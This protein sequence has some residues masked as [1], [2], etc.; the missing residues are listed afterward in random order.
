VIVTGGTSAQLMLRKTVAGASAFTGGAAVT[1]PAL[2]RLRRVG[3][4]FSA[5]LSTDDG[6]T[7]TPLADGEIPGFGD[8]PYYVGLVG[9]SRSQ[10]VR[11]TTEF[12][13]VSITPT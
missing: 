12:D 1:L 8:A 7:W 4:A 3:T 6:V 2:L 10:L 9:C 13:E 5:A 11:C